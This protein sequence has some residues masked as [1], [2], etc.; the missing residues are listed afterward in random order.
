MYDSLSALMTLADSDKE[1]GMQVDP[2]CLP[3]IQKYSA[4]SMTAMLNATVEISRIQVKNIFSRVEN[5]VLEIFLL[6]EKE[7]GNLDDLDID[8]S[9]KK[10]EEI[11]GIT[12]D[13]MVMIYNES[14]ITIGD[15]N[16][17]Q[18]TNISTL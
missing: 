6:L 1:I 2:S 10:D 7:F 11:N 18:D 4:L 13:I 14:S 9:V 12:N 16:K 3:Y 8:L 5:T 17:I 15:H